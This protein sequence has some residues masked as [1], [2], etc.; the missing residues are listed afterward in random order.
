MIMTRTKDMHIAFFVISHFR[1]VLL[2]EIITMKKHIFE[3]HFLFLSPF[4]LM[5]YTRANQRSTAIDLGRFSKLSFETNIWLAEMLKTS[6]WNAVDDEFIQ[7][8]RTRMVRILRT[9]SPRAIP[10]I[11]SS[12]HSSL[13]TYQHLFLRHMF[14]YQECNYFL[15]P[16]LESV[17][18]NNYYCIFVKILWDLFLV[19]V[20]YLWWYK[21]SEMN[22]LGLKS[23]LSSR[24]WSEKSII[25][26]ASWILQSFLYYPWLW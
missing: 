11:P 1:F 20:W 6:I 12:D 22:R 7:I 23:L 25:I 17:Q 4:P 15:S 16:Y 9:N 18:G 3:Q 24:N 5:V 14:H 26:S 19:N 13:I 8:S 10:P 2:T 21:N